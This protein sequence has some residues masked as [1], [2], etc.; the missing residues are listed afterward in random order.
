MICR[1]HNDL[2]LGSSAVVFSGTTDPTVLEAY[3][4]RKSLALAEDLNLQ[5]IHIASDCKEVIDSIKEKNRAEYGA[6][7]H[8]IIAY[9][10]SFY[11][12]NFVH[13][14]R[15]SNMEPHNLAKH[16]L[17][18][19]VGRRVWLGHPENLSFVPAE[20]VTP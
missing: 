3:T 17:K 16:A 19:G 1:D 9:S 5:S 6:I 14:F 4:C 13:E 12:C 10:S 7:V 20:L 15:S 8:E 2:Y 11:S 18:L